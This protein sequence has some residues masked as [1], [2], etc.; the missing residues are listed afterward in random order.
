M[1]G[2]ISKRD[3]VI[4][5][6]WENSRRGELSANRV[7]KAVTGPGAGPPFRDSE[8]GLSTATER[9]IAG[10]WWYKK[11]GI[12]AVQL[13]KFM[14]GRKTETLS[15]GKLFTKVNNVGLPSCH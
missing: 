14:P 12:L 3:G 4:S 8:T 11:W 6:R 9:E 13:G 7:G 15:F 2:Q 1:K 10:E 5:N